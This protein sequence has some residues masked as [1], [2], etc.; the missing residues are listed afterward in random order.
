MSG[1][2]PE[3]CY[4]LLQLKITRVAF[5]KPTGKLQSMDTTRWDPEPLYLEISRF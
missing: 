2:G 5:L 1:S 4:V 3:S